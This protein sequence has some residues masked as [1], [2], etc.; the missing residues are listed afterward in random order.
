MASEKVRSVSVLN[1]NIRKPATDRDLLIHQ[2]GDD[3]NTVHVFIK[4]VGSEM[5][6][7]HLIPLRFYALCFELEAIAE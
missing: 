3:S 4:A 2:N 7:K 6:K 5:W 1:F